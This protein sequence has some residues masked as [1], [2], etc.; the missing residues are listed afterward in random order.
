MNS[1]SQAQK[2]L[3]QKSLVKSDITFEGKILRLR[4]DTHKV[5]KNTKTFE[6]IE[7]PGAVVIIP[8]DQHNRVMLVQQWRRAAQEILIELPAG[9]LEKNE[10]PVACAL[11]ELRE[12]TGFTAEK[13]TPLG[14]FFTAPGFCTEYLHLFAAEHLKPDPLPLDEDEGIDLLHLSLTEAI[15]LI[16]QHKIRDAKTIAGLLLYQL[17]KGSGLL[18]PNP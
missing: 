5:E 16:D 18:L 4:I 14:G 15:H 6:I 10:D 12:E 9:T 8:V 3:E 2:E 7:H 1:K 13:L 11:R 17:S